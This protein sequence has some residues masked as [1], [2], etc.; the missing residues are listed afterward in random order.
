MTGEKRIE[1]LDRFEELQVVVSFETQRFGA[2]EYPVFGKN[3][4]DFR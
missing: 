4:E 2:G 3:S 1:I